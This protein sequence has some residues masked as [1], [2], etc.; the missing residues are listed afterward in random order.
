MVDVEVETALS[1]NVVDYIVNWKLENTTQVGRSQ[2]F[3][4]IG[5]GWWLSAL[6]KASAHLAAL[7][8][9]PLLSDMIRSGIPFRYHVLQGLSCFLLFYFL[10]IQINDLRTKSKPA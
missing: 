5:W 2:V 1:H 6:S 7:W 9:G 8:V 4:Y 10:F 3:R